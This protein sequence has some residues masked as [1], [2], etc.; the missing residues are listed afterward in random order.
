VAGAGYLLLSGGLGGEPH[1]QAGQVAKH[2]GVDLSGGVH[3]INGEVV[4]RAIDAD[5]LMGLGG[6]IG[7]FF[8]EPKDGAFIG[9]LDIDEA[10]FA[11]R[12]LKGLKFN[13]GASGIHPGCLA[14]C[15]KPYGRGSPWVG[16]AV[17]LRRPTVLRTVEG[18]GARSGTSE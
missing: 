13:H 11:G 15:A 10:A 18:G 17:R 14:V 4:C 1:A 9:F 8:S 7:G 16:R 5:A 2:L 3:P 6:G 12:V